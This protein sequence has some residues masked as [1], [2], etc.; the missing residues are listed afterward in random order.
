MYVVRLLRKHHQLL[1]DLLD[2]CHTLL[3][4]PRLCRLVAKTLDEHFHVSNVALL[5][6]A[7]GTELLK[8]FLALVQVSG[9]VAGIGYQHTI[10]QCGHMT[11]ASVHKGA[12]V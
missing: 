2:F 8:V 1:L 12:V 7:L 6:R 4:L 11:Y 10:F 5:S 3:H 9:V